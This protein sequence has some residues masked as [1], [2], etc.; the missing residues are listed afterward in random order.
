MGKDRPPEGVETKSVPALRSFASVFVHAD[1]ADVALMV[2]GLV[3]AMGDGMSTP[4]TMLIASRI[5]NTAGSGPDQLQQFS[6]KM[7]EVRIALYAFLTSSPSLLPCPVNTITDEIP[8]GRPQPE[9][10][11]SP[12]LG[13]RQLDHGVPG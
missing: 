3:G 5:F 11:E 13:S 7:N 1:A 10:K 4:I 8:N 9:R 2:L 12:H 6:A